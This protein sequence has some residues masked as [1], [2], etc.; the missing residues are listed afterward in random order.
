MMYVVGPILD[1]VKLV[2]DY[3]TTMFGDC[4]SYLLCSRQENEKILPYDLLRSDFFPRCVDICQMFV[5]V[6]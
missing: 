4:Q 5:P 2:K 3:M 6:A 1:K